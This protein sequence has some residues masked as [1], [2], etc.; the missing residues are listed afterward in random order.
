MQIP[1]IARSFC[2]LS[3]SPKTPSAPENAPRRMLLLALAGFV[4]LAGHLAEAALPSGDEAVHG[5]KEAL[6]RGATAAVKKLGKPGGFLGDERV[7]I[8]LPEKVQRAEQLMRRFGAGK[9]ADQL[10]ATMNQAAETAV[11][12]ATPILWAAV[13]QMSVN[14][15]VGIIKGKNDAATQ[16]FRRTTDTQLSERLRPLIE[17]ATAKVGVA[18]KY[19]KFAGKAS[20]YGLL[21]AADADLDAYIT[22][23]ALDGLFVMI[24]EE[25]KAIRKDPVA[26]GS[27]LLKKV[28]GGLLP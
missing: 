18:Q 11:V 19:E 17:A 10:I 28:F 7:R 9:Y 5:L 20:R 16:Y 14:D 27:A 8:Q 23:K 6:T 26:T 4:A 25:E 1:M 13:R 3:G 12:E 22:R 21:D 15:G 2:R 24:A